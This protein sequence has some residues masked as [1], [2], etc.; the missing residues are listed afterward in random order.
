MVASYICSRYKKTFHQPIDEMKLHKLLYFTQREAIVQTGEPMFSE[1]FVAWKYGPVMQEIRALYKN[2]RLT[3]MPLQKDIDYYQHVFDI[4]FKVYAPR[5]SWS[6]SM[7][8]HDEYSWIKARNGCGVDDSCD[9]LI[10]IND[11]REDARRIHF[12]RLLYSDNIASV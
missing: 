8:S 11:I 12:R 1:Q 4:V 2:G 9:T 6:L 3:T 7:L 5:D 10:D